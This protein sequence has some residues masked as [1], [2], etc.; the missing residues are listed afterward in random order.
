[1]ATMRV[2]P[3][4]DPLEDAIFASAWLLNRRR[5][6]TSRSSV[7]KKLSAIALSYASPTEPIDGI[8]PASW[9]RLPNA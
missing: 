5:F 3:A 1:V 6:S 9:Q 2:V 4:L 8:T 7:A